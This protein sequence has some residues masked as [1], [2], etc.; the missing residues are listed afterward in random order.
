M[1]FQEKYRHDSNSSSSDS[2]IHLSRACELSP[3]A[4]PFFTIS[5][6]SSVDDEEHEI[7]WWWWRHWFCWLKMSA[8]LVNR[9]WLNQRGLIKIWYDMIW[10]L[11]SAGGGQLY[12]ILCIKSNVQIYD[13]ETV[14]HTMWI[15]NCYIPCKVFFTTYRYIN[16]SMWRNGTLLRHSK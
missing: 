1:I 4:S 13:K 8:I 5:T 15:L 12:L 3:P 7:V 10:V 14:C 2:G 16:Y 9:T 6:T 11:L